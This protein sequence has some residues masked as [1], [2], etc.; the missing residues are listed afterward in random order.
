MTRRVVRYGQ[1]RGQLGELWRP[2][3]PTHS[4][5][6]LPVVVLIHGGFWRSQY[7]KVLMRRLARSVI[8]HGW[9]AW[10][11]EYARVGPFGGGGGWPT[12]FEDVAAAVDELARFDGIDLDR[13]VT[14]GHSAGGQLAL[15]LAARSQSRGDGPGGVAQVPVCAAVSLAGVVDLRAAFEQGGRGGAVAKLLGGAPAEVPERYDSVSPIELLPLGVPQVLVHG[16][17]DEVVAPA[18]S[19]GY[20]IQAVSAGD[21]AV[22]VGIPDAGHRDMLRP[23]GPGWSAALGHIQQVFNG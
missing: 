19:E 15:W 16:L 3:A 5:R 1:R 14:C 11:I 2:A 17:A 12:T 4:E 22:F 18:V 7:T 8:E 23:T 21:D 13:V 20:V 9:A 6:D 10:N